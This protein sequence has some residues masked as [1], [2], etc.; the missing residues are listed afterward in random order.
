MPVR[1][2]ED[3]GGLYFLTGE[4]AVESPIGSV[5]IP[6]PSDIDH[7]CNRIE[8]DIK[9]NDLRIMTLNTAGLGYG[10]GY[11]RSIAKLPADT[12]AYR[13]AAVGVQRQVNLDKLLET[14]KN[15][16]I[17]TLSDFPDIVDYLEQLKRA[18]YMVVNTNY[19]DPGVNR[20]LSNIETSYS[21]IQLVN[22]NRLGVPKS[23]EI[24]LTPHYQSGNI[25]D[26]NGPADWGAYG[27]EHRK[28]NIR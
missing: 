3:S 23:Y 26:Q 18:G 7:S 4:P 24:S 8:G 2:D 19:M 13:L 9:E 28:I 27:G 1:Q 5:K 20:P 14:I 12:Y 25:A 21:N 16:D 22:C 15:Y 17:I 11:P 10:T 6:E